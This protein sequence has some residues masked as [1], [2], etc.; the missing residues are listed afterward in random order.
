[1]DSPRY[2]KVQCLADIHLP[3]AYWNGECCYIRSKQK[4]SPSPEMRSL[5]LLWNRLIPLNLSLFVVVFVILLS[6]LFAK[7]SG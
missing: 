3:Y 1:M 7:T 4:R 6:N 2:Q 5:T